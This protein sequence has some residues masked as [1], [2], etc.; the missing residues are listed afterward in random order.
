MNDTLGQT[1]E[2]GDIVVINA[3]TYS[4]LKIAKIDHFNPQSVSCLMQNGS[5]KAIPVHKVL[6]ISDI[7]S[8]QITAE[9]NALIETISI[10]DS[11]DIKMSEL[12]PG[13]VYENSGRQKYLYIGKGAMIT[14]STP[15]T[16]ETTKGHIFIIVYEMD[17]NRYE[18]G[19]GFQRWQITLNKTKSL[20]RVSNMQ[21]ENAVY[22]FMSK[23]A[24]YRERCGYIT[25]IE[26][27]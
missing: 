6:K 15:D 1:L 27:E 11:P 9:I 21:I 14:P 3:G 2:I 18:T 8:E 25:R 19:Q 22:K 10:M 23:F 17:D 24:E 16:A 20:K 5:R 26:L 12:V 13:T 4:G 7:N